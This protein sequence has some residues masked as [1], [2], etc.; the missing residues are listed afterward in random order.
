M[1]FL[2][3][4]WFYDVE[5]AAAKGRDAMRRVEFDGDCVL[6]VYAGRSKH[7]PYNGKTRL[8]S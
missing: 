3:D 1:S 7:L 8:A 2:V 6:E 5:L 4:A